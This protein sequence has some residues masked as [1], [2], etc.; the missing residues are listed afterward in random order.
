MLRWQVGEKNIKGLNKSR[1]VVAVHQ[2][3]LEDDDEEKGGDD[4]ENDRFAIGQFHGA[5][6]V[7]RRSGRGVPDPDGTIDIRSAS[8]SRR[9]PVGS[10]TGYAAEREG[11]T[12][13]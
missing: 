5:S 9:A 13:S 10:E 4:S 2:E 3:H 6:T 7:P 1:R 8:V 12:A 11:T